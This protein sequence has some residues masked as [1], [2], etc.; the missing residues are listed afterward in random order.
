MGQKFT[1]HQLPIMKGLAGVHMFLNPGGSRELHSHVIAAEWAYVIGG[2]CQ[3]VVLDPSR[4]DRDQQERCPGVSGLEGP[5]PIPSTR[6][7]Q[8]F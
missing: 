6:R 4:T 8:R 2:R 7:R 3:T 5:R 1:E